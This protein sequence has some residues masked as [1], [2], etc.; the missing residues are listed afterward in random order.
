MLFKVKNRFSGSVQFVA[1]IDCKETDIY[2]LKIGLAVKWAISNRANLTGAD[3]TGANLTGADLYRADL[4]RANLTVANMTGANMTGAN[5]YL[6]NLTGADHAELTIAK[7][8]I[9]PDGDIIGW[10]KCRNNVIVKLRIPEDAKRTNAFGRKCRAEYVD[11]ID[12]IGSDVAISNHDG[13]TEYRI[14][15]RVM[16]D[17]FDE[18]WQNEC[19]SGIHFFITREEAEAY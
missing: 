19:S 4:H 8:R 9:I 6:A 13:K 14:G 15:E 18:S 1:E 12:V 7:T 2:S 3:L 16:P 5:M 17:R 10:K 11:V